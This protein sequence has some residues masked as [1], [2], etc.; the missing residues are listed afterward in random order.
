MDDY[1]DA[2]WDQAEQDERQRRE[3]E[4]LARHAKLLEEFRSANAACDR[5]T[6]DF[7]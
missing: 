6:R 2:C 5:E 3:D 4:A 1:D 7:N